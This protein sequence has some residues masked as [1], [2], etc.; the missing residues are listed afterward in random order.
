MHCKSGIVLHVQEISYIFYSDFDTWTRLLGL[1]LYIHDSDIQPTL[2]SLL[3]VLPDIHFFKRL[4]MPPNKWCKSEIHS[5]FF[6]LVRL[7]K[8]G[9]TSD[10]PSSSMLFLVRFLK[11]D[12]KSLLLGYSVKLCTGKYIFYL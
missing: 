8:Y 9:R 3:Y 1:I 11:Q 7:R 6:L 5:Y 12:S 4:R 10:S 2:L